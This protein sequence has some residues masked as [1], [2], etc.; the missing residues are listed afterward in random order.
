VTSWLDRALRKR[1]PEGC[2]LTI[3][4]LLCFCFFGCATPYRPMKKGKGFTDFQIAPDQFVVT[5]QGNGQTDS[6]RVNDFALLRAA[7]VS[8]QHG[9]PY[10]AIADITNTST[11]RPYVVRQRFHSD[12]PPNTG[13]PSPA[14]FGSEPYQF[15]YAVEYD[16]PAL[17][18]RP[19]ERLRIQCFK[20]KPAKPFTYDAVSLEAS[21]KRKY[22][23]PPLVNASG[24]GAGGKMQEPG[25]L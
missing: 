2:L 13:L 16:Q 20:A 3:S 14:A 7:Q 6:Q 19:G 17:Y 21:L 25:A 12:Y 22:K 24:H 23:L 18:V 11:V 1:D 4:A 10:F 15:G 8:L 9:F 5:F